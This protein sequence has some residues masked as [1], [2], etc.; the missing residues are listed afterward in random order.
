MS[1]VGRGPELSFLGAQLEPA[2]LG[3]PRLV[4]VEGPPGIGKTALVQ[5]FLRTAEE[6]RVLRAV[7]DENE[8]SLDYGVLAQLA[9]QLPA[10]VSGSL[11]ALTAP[12]RD[13]A[14]GTS[15]ISA[16]WALLE[17][18]GDVQGDRP[19]VVVVDDAHW[20]DAASVQALTFAFRRSPAG[21]V[22]AIVITRGATGPP[23]PAALRRLMTNDSALRLRL[24][25]LGPA[26]VRALS[27]HLGGT[28]LSPHA[29]SRLHA[30]TG[31]HPL[32]VRSLLEENP[33]EVLGDLSVPLPAPRSYARR[34]LGR[35]ADLHEDSR[36]LV[37]AASVLGLASSLSAA[38]DLAGVDDPLH[39]LENAVVAGLL[40]ERPARGGLEICFAHPLTHAAVYHGLGP[41]QRVQLHLLA[42][43]LAGGEA[44]RLRHRVRAADLPDQ[45]LVSELVEAGRGAAAT[46]R[47]AEA[48]ERL[49]HAARLAVTDEQRARLTAEAVE[50]SLCDG[51]I[52][53][54]TALIA[55]LDLDAD[56]CV[57][58]YALGA[59]ATATGRAREAATLLADAWE[60]CDPDEDPEPAARIAEQRTFTSL[61]RGHGE[62]G[63]RWAERS[64]ALA[65]KRRAADLFATGHLLCLVGRGEIERALRITACLPAPAV[66]TAEE[67][68][69]LLG[70]GLLLALTDDLERAVYE[71]SDVVAASAQRSAPFRLA[72][73]ALLGFAEYRLGRWDDAAVHAETATSLAGD[74]GRIWVTAVAHGIA[75]LVPA[76]RG[77]DEQAAAHLRAARDMADHGVSVGMLAAAT[78]QAHLA[79][80]HGDA[81]GLA[82]ELAPLLELGE[83][84][85]DPAVLPWHDLVVDGLITMGQ[86]DRAEAALVPYEKLAAAHQRR[87]ALAAAMR[88]RGNLEA[89][90]NAPEAAAAAYRSGLQHA[91]SVPCP[92]DRAR[93]DLDYGAFLRRR[94]K[95]TIAAE[96]L[97]A[98]RVS[99]ELLDAAPYLERCDRELAACG[100]R[101]SGGA[102]A[103]PARL[104]A[105]ERAVARLVADGMTN[106]QVARRLVVS[107]KT[108]EYHLGN[109]YTKLDVHSRAGLAAKLTASIRAD[110]C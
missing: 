91:A 51:R 77:Q 60:R 8:T 83:R 29:A 40:T 13:D 104:T 19:I 34:V 103:H 11:A 70:R 50:A 72:A 24:G 108:I 102:G 59:L 78:G 66:A 106:Q 32:H 20:A 38:A 96:R 17:M 21:R 73:T 67:L 63:L 39:A 101:R 61:M 87:S 94:G 7:G 69:A 48:A 46:G 79:A 25:G 5:H 62:D 1:F 2:R 53:E 35:L 86:L 92:F 93:L 90:R 12:Y 52:A 16:G 85:L 84:A 80:A 89:A 82:T 3:E 15:P 107:V 47:W 37:V 81:H 55:G 43:K 41:A 98:A 75:A 76:A 30:H 33:A 36:D 14:E 54:A 99:L 6:V 45:G 49:S 10:A 44:D 68:D 28:A 31:G 109:V 9:G 18:L 88:V 57:R 97:Q 74:M 26:D 22:L 65:P 27:G 4:S 105:R 64:R 95:R 42:A 100:Q 23:P 71:L 58:R 56:S 110:E